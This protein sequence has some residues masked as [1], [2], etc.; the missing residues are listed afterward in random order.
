MERKDKE[1]WIEK[2]LS[3]SD[4]SN[5]FKQKSYSFK[6]EIKD[7]I[8]LYDKQ[9]GKCTLCGDELVFDTGKVHIDHIKAKSKGGLDEIENYQFLCSDCNYAKRNMD[10]KDFLI[11]CLKISNW[12][13]NTLS[14]SDKESII[15]AR[16]K[17]EN[18][19]NYKQQNYKI[20]NDGDLR[21]CPGTS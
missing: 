6:V 12:H 5:F 3:N 2:W 14:K 1:I 15:Q 8:E 21:I 4:V 17:L 16:W 18:K 9:K 20:I 19:Y 11:L 10:T 13:N 7:L